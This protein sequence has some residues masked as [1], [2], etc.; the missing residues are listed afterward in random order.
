MDNRT[1]RDYYE[2]LGVSR[3]AGQDEIRRAYR[4]LARQYHP[5]VNHESGA[6]IRFKEISEAY[7]I[8]SDSEKRAAYDRF[9]HAGVGNGAPNFGGFGGDPFGG[10][11]FDTIFESF[12]GGGRTTQRGPQGG[13]DLRYHMTLDFEEAV[14]GG[15]KTI[16]LD[17]LI[18]CPRCNGRRT[19]VGSQP[20][21]C[22]VCGGSG[23]MRRTQTSFIGQF[24]SVTE[25]SRCHGEG[26]IITDPCK[27]CRGQG[28]V[29]DTQRLEVHIPAGIDEG[30]RLRL[31][32]Q[33]EPGD[34]GAAPGDL[35]IDFSVR[36]HP[37][38]RRIGQ[39]LHL[40]MPIN[41][42]QASLGDQIEVPT[43]E[44]PVDVKV[45]PGTQSGDT[46]RIRG[47][48]VPALRGSGRGD[49]VLTYTVLTPK[50]LNS[51]QKKLLRELGDTLE[52]P[53][54]REGDRGFFDRV[55]DA[56]GL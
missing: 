53:Q 16:E 42:V 37:L 7:E 44:D 28:K 50:H 20:V 30:Y 34:P 29:R 13:A 41:L 31:T 19:E 4:K 25:C 11:N 15:T 5:D 6:D 40:D 33:G 39:D 49:L 36:P 26:S 9:G 54:P 18:E 52:K 23:E 12:F 14:F 8:L 3:S 24:V 51:T 21:R 1:K 38:F 35:S 17:K 46:Y 43:L 10:I 55:R 32:G 22:P 27:E 56:L 45:E 47:Q 2:V 48:G